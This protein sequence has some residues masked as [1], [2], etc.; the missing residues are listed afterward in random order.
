MT[1][2]AQKVSN[3]L[4]KYYNIAQ[5][6]MPTQVL[7]KNPYINLEQSFATWVAHSLFFYSRK[8]MLFIQTI[9]NFWRKC[10]LKLISCI[11][12]MKASFLE[13]PWSSTYSFLTTKFCLDNLYSTPISQPLD[14]TLHKVCMCYSDTFLNHTQ[15]I[16]NRCVVRWESNNKHQKSTCMKKIGLCLHIL[17]TTPHSIVN[18]IEK[19]YIFN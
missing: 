5:C 1:Q 12:M 17:L 7:L 15:I 16:F 10:S 14:A 3:Y 11:N 19:L 9:H 2:N 4:V 18:T 8:I 13:D 6:Q